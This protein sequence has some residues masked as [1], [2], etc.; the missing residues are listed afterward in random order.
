MKKLFFSLLAI[1]A[2]FVSDAS[3]ID[4]TYNTS[5]AEPGGFGFRKTET[6]DVAI[7]ITDPTVVGTK[8]TGLSVYLPVTQEA[9]TDL[10]GWLASELRLVDKKNAP[11]IASKEAKLENY[12]LSTT[13]DTPVEITEAG[14]WAGYSFTITSLDAKY[15]YPGNPVA[16]VSSTTNLDKGLWMHTSRTRLKW[17][18]LGTAQK[19]VSPMVIHLQTEFGDTDLAVSVSGEIYMV[20]GKEGSVPAMLINHGTAP[21]EDIE[22]SYT[23]GNVT[24][25]GTYSLETPLATGGKTVTVE[26]PLKASSE[27][28]KYDLKLTIDKNNGKP[29]NDPSSTAQGTVNVWS[30]IPVTRPLVE[31][32]TGLGCGFCPRGYV[33]MEYMKERLGDDFVGLAFHSSGFEKAMATVSSSDFPIT[34]PGYPAADINRE[35]IIDPMAIPYE[36]EAFAARVSNADISLGIEWTD[37]THKT[38][39]LTSELKFMEDVDAADYRLTFA[40]AADNLHNPTWYQLNNYAGQKKGDG[41][42]TPIWD[43]FLKGASAVTGLIFNDVVIYYKDIK[44]IAESVPADADANT[45][46]T[47]TYTVDISELRNLSGEDFINS[48]AT[49]HGVVALIDT[50]TGYAVN[51]CRSAA[52]PYS[53][54]P[55]GT[56]EISTGAVVESSEFYNLQG[57]PVPQPTEGI[58]IR[59]DRMSD[60]T[61]RTSK[62]SSK[63]L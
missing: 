17:A 32:Y 5:G 26:L 25:S 58:Y 8:I 60:G 63:Q 59:R 49:L 43:I 23:F 12:T 61:V 33:A 1:A 6:Y 21:V 28:G 54:S 11:D 41:V 52:L 35:T 51:S 3:D 36:F 48:D 24:G 37:D 50:K 34:V 16:V 47:Y 38:V 29:N 4:F 27:L 7:N 55:A 19:S 18:E 45:T 56:G 53:D 2:S 57:I 9:V 15:G 42:D 44:G 22:Y 31:E 13:F 10:S 14:I 40:L 20:C 46:Y 30:R 62:I 39:E